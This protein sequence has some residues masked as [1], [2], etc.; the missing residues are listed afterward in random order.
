MNLEDPSLLVTGATGQ[1]ARY[2]FE[3]LRQ[4]KFDKKI[5][6]IIRSNSKVNKINHDKLF[7][8]LITCDFNDIDSLRDA[9]YGVKTVLHIAHI[10]LTE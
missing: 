2:F 4:E 9:M 7:I 5:K 10:T 3:R 1:T 8:E 6:C